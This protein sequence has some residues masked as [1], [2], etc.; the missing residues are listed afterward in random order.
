VERLVSSVS[1]ALRSELLKKKA[2]LGA[3]LDDIFVQSQEQ[4]IAGLLGA[5]RGE[6]DILQLVQ[7][8]K[9][10]NRLTPSLIIRALCVGDIPF[11]EACMA[12][13][14]GIPIVNARV[15]IHDA[16]KLGLKSLYDKTALPQGM[17][18]IIRV[19]LEVVKEI[20]LDGGAGDR[21]RF[22]AKVIERILTQYEDFDPDDLGYL[23][24]KLDDLVNKAA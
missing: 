10:A 5:D 18:A 19:A 13:M 6:Q 2:S 23:L 24:D 20:Q 3:Q 8:L 9:K 7:Q 12:V 16:G 11:F 17:Y 15:L 4:L 22:G 1:D 14:A 21:E